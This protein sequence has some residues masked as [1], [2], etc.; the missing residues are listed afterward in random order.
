MDD[1]KGQAVIVTTAHRGVF[2]GYLVGEPAK[3]RVKITRARCAV[4]WDAG[5][6]GFLGLAEEGPGER[7]RIGKPA[8][9]ITLYDVTAVVE[10]SPAAAE[11]WE[12]G[13]WE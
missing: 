4:Y 5:L 1:V 10:C 11:R 2:F 13:P 12:R 7:C 9:A 6:R 3:A 8:P